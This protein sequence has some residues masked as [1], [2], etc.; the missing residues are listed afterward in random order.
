[1][2]IQKKYQGA[3]PLNRIANEYNESEINT[4]STDYINN[5]IK[6]INSNTEQMKQDIT[7]LK[8]TSPAIK[9]QH[10]WHD[11][12]W[13]TTFYND[14]VIMYGTQKVSITTAE[15][16]IA[17]VYYADDIPIELPTYFNDTNFVTTA[18]LK[19]DGALVWIY[20][21][22]IIDTDHISVSIASPSARNNVTVTIQYQCIGKRRI[23]Q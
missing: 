5:T 7:T 17:G 21:T 3:V 10:Q 22:D 9:E 19:G 2:K 15:N 16:P 13:Y 20:A 4:Y 6:D 18:T 23:T 1:M 11:T 12:H 14:T 8:S